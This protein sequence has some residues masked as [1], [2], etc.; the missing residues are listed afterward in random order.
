[1][2]A[3]AYRFGGRWMVT[4]R[5]A[6]LIVLFAL[7]T[8]GQ[9]AILAG[10]VYDINGAVIPKVVITFVDSKVTFKTTTDEM[11]EYLISLPVS[12]LNNV[13]TYTVTFDRESIGFQKKVVR[14]FLFVPS[15]KGKMYLD[16]VLQAKPISPM[17]QPIER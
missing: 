4:I 3:W 11:G 14:D 15:T 9:K 8:L 2:I 1:V 7:S 6:L 12:S 17:V 13:T 5:V 16:C 10:T